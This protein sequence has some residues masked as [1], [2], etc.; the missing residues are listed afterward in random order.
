[1]PNYQRKYD[2]GDQFMVEKRY[3]TVI[4]VDDEEDEYL[5][6]WK[7]RLRWKDVREIDAISEPVS[8]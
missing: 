6:S 1:M 2:E 7:G 4:E 8:T 3:H 5:V